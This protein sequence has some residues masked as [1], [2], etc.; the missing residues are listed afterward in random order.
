MN[1]AEAYTTARLLVERKAWWYE[2][3]G[4]PTMPIHGGKEGLLTIKE[5]D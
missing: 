5:L 2:E 3:G 1:L 4:D